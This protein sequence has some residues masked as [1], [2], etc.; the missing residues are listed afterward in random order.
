MI[1]EQTNEPEQSVTEDG[2][3]E[4]FTP[5]PHNPVDG[6]ESTLNDERRDY[7]THLQDLQNR[8]E[9]IWITE[10]GF[11]SPVPDRTR[12]ESPADVFDLMSTINEWSAE[13][14]PGLILSIETDLLEKALGLL[15]LLE[16][17]VGHLKSA[18]THDRWWDI[19]LDRMFVIEPEDLEHLFDPVHLTPRI[20]QESVSTPEVV[21]TAADPVSKAKAFLDTW[22]Q[23]G[24]SG[25]DK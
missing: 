17:H 14:I 9:D 3:R 1:K 16:I 23:G 18:D 13:R 15:E 19:A 4:A 25:H 8:P 2:K 20:K 21:T 12:V 24:G 5:T 22:D 6:L 10:A 7:I 11:V